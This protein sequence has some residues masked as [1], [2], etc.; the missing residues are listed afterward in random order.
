[1]DVHYTWYGNST[2]INGAI[3]FLIFRSYQRD[4]YS[5]YHGSGGGRLGDIVREMDWHE[6]DSVYYS[7]RAV[8]KSLRTIQLVSE[9]LTLQAI[10]I[11]TLSFVWLSASRHVSSAH[12][13]LKNTLTQHV[14]ISSSRHA[15]FSTVVA[16][17][18]KKVNKIYSHSNI[19]SLRF[20]MQ[21]WTQNEGY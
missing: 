10:T 17:R 20:C 4:Y 16:L 15:D 12:R 8:G 9:G 2:K 1:M 19:Q 3:S 13:L 6:I 5:V 7:E 11:S 21:T 14:L 18:T